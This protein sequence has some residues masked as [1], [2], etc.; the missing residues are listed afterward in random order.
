MHIMKTRTES[1]YWN[2]IL[3][4]QRNQPNVSLCFI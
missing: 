2:D 3:G 4:V 1:R